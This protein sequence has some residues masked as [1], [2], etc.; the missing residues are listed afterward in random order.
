MEKPQQIIQLVL[1]IYFLTDLF[2]SL[3]LP[4]NNK[5]ER[6]AYLTVYSLVKYPIYD[7]RHNV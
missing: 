1:N 6:S 3:A 7:A 4:P 2:S 5:S